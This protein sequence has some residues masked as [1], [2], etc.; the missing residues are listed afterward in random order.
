[1]AWKKY[2]EN[3]HSDDTP[4]ID[5]DSGEKI[6]DNADKERETNQKVTDLVAWAEKMR[7]KPFM[8]TPTQRKMIHTLRTKKISPVVIK[9]TYLDLLQSDYWQKQERLPD[10][11]TVLSA[12]K[13][14]R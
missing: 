9:Q 7:G 13:N 14:K 4:S 6:P 10:F 8:D 3:D 12:L 1:M 5:L 2:N 11:K